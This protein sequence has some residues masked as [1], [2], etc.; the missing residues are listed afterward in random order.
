MTQVSEATVFVVDDDADVRS[1]VLLLLESMGYR[2]LGFGSAREFL[3]AELPEGPCCL[4]LDVRMPRMNGLDLQRE[5]SLAGKNIPIIFVTGH[6]TVPAS[7]K[8][9]KAGAVDFLE[10]PFD[11][12]TLLDAVTGAIEKSREGVERERDLAGARRRVASL[13]PREREVFRLVVQGRPNKE[14]ADKLGM[15]ESTVK[16]HRGRVMRKLAARSLPDLVRIAD[17]LS[18]EPPP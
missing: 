5:L 8:A 12:Q 2:A 16:V 18:V 15:R 6:A 17:R 10:K 1:G 9:M 3:K 13:T 4:I 7:V 11:E 14:I